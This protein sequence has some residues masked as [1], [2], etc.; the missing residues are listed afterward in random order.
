VTVLSCRRAGGTIATLSTV[1]SRRRRK[2]LGFHPAKAISNEAVVYPR[3][4]RS[5]LPVA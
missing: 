3:L 4:V 2:E 5:D 1:G